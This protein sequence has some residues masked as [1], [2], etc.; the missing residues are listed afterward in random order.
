MPKSV[1][2]GTPWP[3]HEEMVRHLRVP[4]ARQKELRALADKFYKRISAEKES[5][6]GVKIGRQEISKNAPAAD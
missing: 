3:T 6:S 2:I 4:R 1:N 5:A